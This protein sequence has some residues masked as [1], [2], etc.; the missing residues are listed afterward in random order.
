MLSINTVKKTFVLQQ[1]QSDCGVACLISLTQYYGGTNTLEKLREL[2]GTN[3]TGTTLLGLYQCANKIGFTAEAFEADMANLKAL[4]EPCVLH[5]LMDGNLQHYV[6]CYGYDTYLGIF[7]VGD[8]GKGLIELTE[9]EL[10]KIWQSKT[11]LQLKPNDS[12]YLKKKSKMRSG[13]GL[14]V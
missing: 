1:D 4:N 10:N 8:P 9:T 3:T 12:F 2:S 13:F 11:L 14:R 5:V 7:I 6:V